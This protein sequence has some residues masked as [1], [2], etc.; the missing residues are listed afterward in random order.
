MTDAIAGGA[1]PGFQGEVVGPDHPDY[2]E[3]RAVFNGLVDKRPSMLLR[4]GDTADIA[5]AVRAAVDSGSEIAV[6][7]GGHSVA[8]HSST[9]GGIVIDLS[10]MR[11]IEVAP[12]RRRAIVEPGATWRDID[13]ATGRHGLACPGGVVSS[14]GVGG[15][16]LGGG[17]GWLAR[18]YGLTCDNLVAAE[19]VLASGEV[20]EVSEAERP[21]VLW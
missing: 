19:L 1:P 11:G 17:V 4:C 15:F 18:S 3:A 12:Q 21:D 16:A 14:T 20:I 13:R 8:G 2:D 5:A 10:T 9:D 6:R 7:C